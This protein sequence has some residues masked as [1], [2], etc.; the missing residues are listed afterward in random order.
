[1]VL[2]AD[3]KSESRFSEARAL[4][5][6]VRDRENNIKNII[7]CFPNSQITPKGDT[8]LDTLNLELE[9]TLKSLAKDKSAFWFLVKV[10][11]L[12]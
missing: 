2:F 3:A 12:R 7:L 10:A 6:A 4:L 8:E 1:M 11:V 5:Q 9:Y